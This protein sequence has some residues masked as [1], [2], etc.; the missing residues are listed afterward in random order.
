MSAGGGES[1]RRRTPHWGTSEPLTP[2]RA[3][4]TQPARQ[5]E[6]SAVFGAEGCKEKDSSWHKGDAQG[7]WILAFCAPQSPGPDG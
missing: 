1:Y 6:R 3:C 4:P 7:T 5:V 2:R